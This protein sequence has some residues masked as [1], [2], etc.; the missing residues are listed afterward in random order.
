M[1]IEMTPHRM[2]RADDREE[3]RIRQAA[4]EHF[5]ETLG[6]S[7]TQFDALMGALDVYRLHLTLLAIKRMGVGG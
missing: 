5:R 4:W 2:R 6:T 3:V 7:T 1:S